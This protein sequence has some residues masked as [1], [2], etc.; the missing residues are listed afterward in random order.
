MGHVAVMSYGYCQ[1]C[2]KADASSLLSLEIFDGGMVKHIED[3][4]DVYVHDEEDDNDKI[5]IV[6]KHNEYFQDLIMGI[7]QEHPEFKITIED[8]EG[9]SEDIELPEGINYDKDSLDSKFIRVTMPEVDKN[10]RDLINTAVDAL[11]QVCKTRMTA[12][13]VKCNAQVTEQLIGAPEADLEEA[14]KTMEEVYDQYKDMCNNL[15]DDKK[16]EVEEAY[17]R[18]LTGK[19]AE[20][21]KNDSDPSTVNNGQ[22]L[23]M[24]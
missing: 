3:V 10:R 13:Q 19:D 18:Y 8:G 22:S 7:N 20:Q 2:V 23:R 11:N 1:L 4:A 6:P 16:K 15:T 14:K 24:E 17:Q 9:P 5:D 12:C 21:K